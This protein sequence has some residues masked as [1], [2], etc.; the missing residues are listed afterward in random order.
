MPVAL[1]EYRQK[2]P[3]YSDIDDYDL[4]QAL[5]RKYQSE[6]GSDISRE[7]FADNIGAPRPMTD[8][9]AM[10]L[11][12][13]QLPPD[14]AYDLAGE[15]YGAAADLGLPI[16]V[17]EPIA[18]TSRAFQR[19]YPQWEAVSPEEAEIKDEAAEL[20]DEITFRISS[21]VRRA[22]DDWIF[23]VGQYVN[24]AWDKVGDWIFGKPSVRQEQ[25][26]EQ[27][28]VYAGTK[29]QAF[30]SK[31][32]ENSPAFAGS[33]INFFFEL[34]LT[35]GLIRFAEA[36][37][38]A[39][40][41]LGRARELAKL[42][43]LRSI[44]SAAG[45]GVPPKEAVI[46]TAVA[47]G[48][49][50]MLGGTGEG[51]V[52]QAVG[53]P[54]AF[55][56]A[57]AGEVALR[58]GTAEEQAKAALIG[59]L[60]GFSWALVRSIAPGFI[61]WLAGQKVKHFNEYAKITRNL[62]REFKDRLE[63]T[64]EFRKA[65]TERL[66]QR[67]ADKGIKDISKLPKEFRAIMKSPE[68]KPALDKALK[69]RPKKPVTPAG[70]P[71]PKPTVATKIK[72]TK[73]KSTPAKEMTLDVAIKEI[74][75]LPNLSVQA[76]SIAVANVR[77][78][79]DSPAKIK[80]ELGYVRRQSSGTLTLD[81]WWANLNKPTQSTIIGAGAGAKEKAYKVYLKRAVVQAVTKI[82]AAKAKPAAIP[83]SEL[84]YAPLR[85]KD[86][87]NIQEAFRRLQTHA[88]K[89]AKFIKSITIADV[90]KTTISGSGVV[91]LSNQEAKWGVDR[92]AYVLAHE[93]T[94]GFQNRKI[95]DAATKGNILTEAQ[96]K[97]VG[98]AVQTRFEQ[99]KAKPAAPEKVAA[100]KSIET[101]IYTSV[102]QEWKKVEKLYDWGQKGLRAQFATPSSITLIK[103][104][105]QRPRK[106][107]A[108]ED[109]FVSL[110]VGENPKL[111]REARKLT[112]EIWPVYKRKGKYWSTDRY[113][114]PRRVYDF[115]TDKGELVPLES[116]VETFT[117]HV[118]TPNLK[119]GIVAIPEPVGKAA[120]ALAKKTK[121]VAENTNDWL[122]QF[123]FY[124]DAPPA[125]RNAIRTDLIGAMN[126]AQKNV[127]GSAQD[128]I[129]GEVERPDA[130]K[131]VEIIFARDQLSRTKLGKGNPEISLK[132]AQTVLDELMAEAGPE[133]IT[134]ADRWKEIHDTY[135][136]KLVERG[137]LDKD[138]L[139]EDHVRHYVEDYT[140]DWAPTFGIPIQMRRPFR[141][142]AKRA[143]GTRKPYRQDHDAL[144]DSL[145]E[146]EYH[147]LVE[148][149]LI[150][151]TA[152][153][154][155]KGSLSRDQKLELF[156][157]S[158]SGRLNTP[159]PGRIYIIDDKRYRAY[160]PDIPFSRGIYMT[161][162]GE[163][164][165]GQ[166]KNVAVIPEE[167]YN[168]FRSFSQ[169][170][171]RNLY[172]LNRA[173]SYWKSMAILSHFPTFNLNNMIGDTWIAMVQHPN[174]ISLVREYDTA[175]R[176]L[177]GKPEG[178]YGKRLED[179]IVK[180]DVK[181]TFTSTELRLGRK[182]KNPAAW[183]LRKS[184]QVSDFRESINRVAYASSLLKAMDAGQGEAMVKAHDWIDT[185]GLTTEEALGKISRDVLTDYAA[186]SKGWRRMVSGG[187]APFGTF[188]FKT[189]ARVW[190]WMWKH[191]VKGLVAFMSLPVLSAAWNNRDKKT[192]ELEAR[193]PDFVR[194]RVHF[195]LG[196]DAAGQVIVSNWQLPQDVLIGTKIFAIVTD[197]ASRVING[198]MTPKEAAI[199]T[200]QTWG[201]REYEGA[202]YLL[203]P[204]LRMYGGLKS[205]KD[206]YDHANVY[207][208]DYGKLTWDEKAKDI[209]A[210]IIKT[211]VP[212]LG[213]TIQ[214][215]E[216]GLPQDVALRKL[217]DRWAGEGVL[218]IYRIS[219][220]GEI[221]IDRKD[222]TQEVL[223]W[224]DVREIRKLVA[225]EGKYLGQLEKA[226]VAS[227]KLTLIEF[228][229]S[230]KAHN[231][232]LALYDQW[233]KQLPEFNEV[234][235]KD[236]RITIVM[237]ALDERL[238]NSL[239]GPR[240]QKRHWIVKL[241]RAK[242]DEEK[243]AL[244]KERKEIDTAQILKAIKAQPRTA[245]MI[246][247]IDKFR[248]N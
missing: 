146:M 22:S 136:Q 80:Q 34:S 155:I 30:L 190:K 37:Q 78:W 39:T 59:G 93:A 127:Y 198:E 208:R 192:K 61:R 74:N 243:Q 131:S 232:L 166:Y 44:F 11:R 247:L 209:A 1:Q 50:A 123:R 21:N 48:L 151:Q 36:N 118:K 248:N 65:V 144:V 206:P 218:G 152:K 26:K 186:V 153:Y 143:T 242:T 235:D 47:A 7:D 234:I 51:I 85:Q 246:K 14:E 154:D 62:R 165:L 162:K 119:P 199:K 43:G 113:L 89:L 147:N 28:E 168:T 160:T 68:W 101:K 211:T 4:G 33:L 222:G 223:D 19:P 187:V 100:E 40:T 41:A 137:V 180:H 88:P 197:Y 46:E 6:T 86:R 203:T 103:A 77:F 121:A 24:K 27:A 52:G 202:K 87:D 56:V 142:Y 133:A 134:A 130:E 181:Q 18:K 45:R 116:K 83:V 9:E 73:V 128:A 90:P 57:G 196:E 23:G 169:R 112:D 157:T 189:T 184:Y 139:I 159:R 177:I 82:E 49:G 141:G 117:A 10:T 96:A 219:P 122:K 71:A 60:Q 120:E 115:L 178:D 212:F 107:F 53:V 164:A 200:L 55:A 132:E 79:K 167:I 38:A 175:L 163:A 236:K 25:V 106:T 210:Y 76:K 54:G 102:P 224:E 138:Q 42:F 229:Q 15:V 124:A 244:R 111:L 135:T 67:V 8:F 17:L 99:A 29:E 213:T 230:E 70:K 204:W 195:I 12:M 217:V 2:H 226:Y 241:S 98:L 194:N 110:Y 227:S 140:P 84:D 32:I 156:G 125:L 215:Y 225:Q 228:M 97:R 185:E 20:A 5:W 81:E 92:L 245:R 3:E 237:G 170:G 35:K 126:K 240:V 172:L 16:Y 158:E 173:T 114:I 220:K 238:V 31:A 176:Y 221:I 145:L 216:K 66:A 179:F 104:E 161:E 129:W 233:A 150:T 148:D 91:H 201:I 171:G 149:F 63:N 205:G 72:V 64:P 188:Y 183:L 182:A 193:L 95:L 239:M 207:R 108:W 58:G 214:S 69:A 174:P 105:G 75:A 13:R 231:I 191:K 94:H 109:Q